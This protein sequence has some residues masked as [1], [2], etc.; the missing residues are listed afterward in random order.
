MLK[1]ID[2]VAV[3]NGPLKLPTDQRN[4]RSGSSFNNSKDVT[5]LSNLQRKYVTTKDE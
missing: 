4:G 3:S 5:A 1:T 2:M